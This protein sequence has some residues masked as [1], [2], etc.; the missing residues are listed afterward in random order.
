MG[1]WL[2]PAHL[3]CVPLG[4]EVSV[5]EAFFLSLGLEPQTGEAGAAV[6]ASCKLTLS[7]CTHMHTPRSGCHRAMLAR[8]AV[9]LLSLTWNTYRSLAIP[10][11]TECGLSCSQVSPHSLLSAGSPDGEH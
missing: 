6:T 8:W 10:R 7:A 2:Q 1:L 4:T 3:G 11:V 5:P 9:T